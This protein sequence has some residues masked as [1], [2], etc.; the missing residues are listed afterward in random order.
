MTRLKIKYHNG[1]K[2]SKNGV[3]AFNLEMIQ[4]MKISS[5]WYDHIIVDFFFH[6]G[7][8]DRRNKYNLKKE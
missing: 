7:H 8:A 1:Q 3:N 4:K 6:Q 5:N 2:L